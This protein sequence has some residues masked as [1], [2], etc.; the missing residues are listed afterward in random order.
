MDL[1]AK[2]LALCVAAAS[3]SY[4]IPSNV[5]FAVLELERDGMEDMA[6]STG[7][8]LIGPMQIS[9]DWATELAIHWNVTNKVALERLSDDGCVNIGVGTW[10]L[11]QRVDETGSLYEAIADFRSVARRQYVS[12]EAKS[13]YRESVI[14]KSSQIIPSIM[15]SSEVRLPEERNLA[16][17]IGLNESG[18]NSDLGD[19]QAGLPRNA[20]QKS[21]LIRL[22]DEGISGLLGGII[23][24]GLVL[25]LRFF[26]KKK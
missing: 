11:R 17:Q 15:P 7:S 20:T 3:Q 23:L 1:T 19:D 21:S 2:A 13:A 26:S 18:L 12:T 8:S 4:A 6:V 14:R 22:I 5:V 16:P 25:L 9:K 24:G 10:I